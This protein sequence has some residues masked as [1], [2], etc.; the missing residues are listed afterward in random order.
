MNEGTSLSYIKFALTLLFLIYEHHLY[1][2]ILNFINPK[3]IDKKQVYDLKKR[4]TCV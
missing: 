3:Y 2:N 4:K 1:N